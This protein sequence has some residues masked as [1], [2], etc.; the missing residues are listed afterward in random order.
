LDHLKGEL[1]MSFTNKNILAGRRI[2]V[3][4]DDVVNAGVFYTCLS[5]QG[6]LIYQDIL[7]YGIVQHILESLPID[8]V[9]MDIMLKRGNNGYQVFEALQSNPRL[10]DI[11]V[12]AVTSL[13]P[14]TQIPKAKE[15]GFA[16]YLSKPVNALELPNQLLRILNGE[17][18]W[19][20]SR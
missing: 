7:G 4:E 20:V 2:F 12:V 18:I 5:R 6:A 9:I 15:M 17:N 8:L 10:K 14:E 1:K 19:L 3:V 13:D 11:P 16:G